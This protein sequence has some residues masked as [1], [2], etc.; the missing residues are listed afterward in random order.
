MTYQE[1]S[2]LIKD[3]VF[4]GRVMIASL[5]YAEYILNEAPSTP[6]HSSRYRWA[7]D[8]YKQPDFVAAQITPPTVMDG[9][10]QSAGAAVTDAALQSAV[11]GVVNKML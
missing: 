3:A 10:V 11:E 9:A 4:R 2:D 6:G 5:K 1:S 7:Q 8:T